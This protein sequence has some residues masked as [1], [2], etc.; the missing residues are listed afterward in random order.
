MNSR[1]LIVDDNKKNIQVL[2]GF[3]TSYGCEVEYALDGNRALAWLKEERFDLVILDVMM[4]G[5]DG[6]EV[7][8]QI[9]QD[10]NLRD[11]PVIFLTAKTDTESI[12][13]GFQAGGVDYVTKPF[14]SYELLNRVQNHLELKHSRDQLKELNSHLEEKVNEK[15]AALQNA[16]EELKQAYNEINL[17]KEKLQ[18]ENTLLKEEITIR[19]NFNEMVGHHP[20]LQQVLN[21]VVQVAKTDATVLIL[22]ET[23]TGKELVARAIYQNSLRKNKPF[24]KINCASIPATLIESELFGHEKGAFT[25]AL[26]K[27]IGRFELAHGGTLFLDEI[28]ELPVELQPKLLR[29]LQEGEF[30]RIGSNTTLKVDVRIIAATNRDLLKETREGRFRSD[31]Y[32]RLNVFPVTLPALKERKDDIPDLVRYFVKRSCEKFNKELLQVPQAEISKLMAYH[33]P[34]NIR[35]LENIVERAVIVSPGKAL[36]IGDWMHIKSQTAADG[37]LQSMENMEKE[38]LLKVLNMTN[39]RIRGDHGAA[40]ILEMKPTTLESRMKKLGI[41]NRPETPI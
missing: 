24:V 2:A 18:S 29:V 8:T 7:C 10:P 40:Q 33:W 15:T 27:K 11:I 21:Q 37:G 38:Y 20:K 17:L 14:N 1:I 19:S 39:W 9:R 6:F 34:G 12:L 28:G 35:E 4:P 5:M 30:E 13:R 36:K 16:F 26:A 23:G 22:G 41:K 31:L 32:Y 25:G 3:L